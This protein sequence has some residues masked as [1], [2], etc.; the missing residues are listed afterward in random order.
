[1]IMAHNRPQP[2]PQWQPSPPQPPKKKRRWLVWLAVGLPLLWLVSCTA[3]LSAVLATDDED[4]TTTVTTSP[5]QDQEPQDQE[6]VDQQ[7]VP[8]PKPKPKPPPLATKFS[9]KHNTYAGIDETNKTWKGGYDLKPG[10][11]RS[12]DDFDPKYT[13]PNTC[14]AWSSNPDSDDLEGEETYD[15]NWHAIL[16]IHDGDLVTSVGCGT[17]KRVS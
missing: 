5:P 9:D 2:H 14:R 8:K 6:T 10:K 3:I 4:A 12:V 13:P 15:N 17:W 7:P 16:K 11:Y 1:M